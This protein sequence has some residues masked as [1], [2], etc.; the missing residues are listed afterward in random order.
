M[1]IS[2]LNRN[3]LKTQCEMSLNDVFGGLFDFGPK[4]RTKYYSF[5]RIVFR[6]SSAY[7][8]TTEVV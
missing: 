1:S 6:R 8:V 3:Q 4:K 5:T 2:G 7:L